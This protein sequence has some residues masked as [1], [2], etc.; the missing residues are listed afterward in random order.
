MA[1][2]LKRLIMGLVV[3]GA[4]LLLIE[5]GV[6]LAMPGQVMQQTP[7]DNFMQADELLGWSPKPGMG[8]PFG[9]PRDTNINTL[10]TRNPEPVAREDGE[11]RLLTLGE[12]DGTAGHPWS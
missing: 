9:V 7:Q 11:I 5:G 3:S 4:V 6:R 10:G 2:P 1:S 8:R 12:L